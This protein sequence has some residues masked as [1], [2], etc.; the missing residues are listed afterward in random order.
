MNEQDYPWIRKWGQYLGSV[1]DYIECQCAEAR[2]E[3]AP[4]NAIHRDHDTGEWRTTDDIRNSHTR[5]ALGLPPLE[6]TNDD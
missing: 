4:D 1:N 6:E 3:G 5:Q 2:S